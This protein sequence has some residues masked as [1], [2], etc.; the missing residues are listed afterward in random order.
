[1]DDGDRLLRVLNYQSGRGQ[2]TGTMEIE[3]VGC[4]NVA[5]LHKKEIDIQISSG[6]LNVKEK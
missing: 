3:E 1:M 5:T 2:W 6:P 4:K